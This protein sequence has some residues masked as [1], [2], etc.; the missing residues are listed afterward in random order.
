M[1]KYLNGIALAVA[2]LCVVPVAAWS[3]SAQA[4]QGGAQQ[5]G[6]SYTMPEYNQFTACQAE[7][8]P[9]SKVK[10]LDGFVSQFPNSTLMQYVDV[11]YYQT[12]Y[13]LKDLK[14][15]IDYA[16]KL[17]ALGD[18]ADLASRVSAMEFRVQ[19]FPY[20]YTTKDPDYQT[21]LTKQRDSALEAVKLLQ[22]YKTAPNS[23]LTDADYKKYLAVDYAAAG[24][25][26]LQLKDNTDAVTAF[27]SALDNNPNDALTEYHLGLAYLAL[28]PPQ[29]LDGF[30]ALARAVDLKVPDADKV[31]DYLRRAMLAYEQPGCVPQ[32]D[33]QLTDLLQMAA[34]SPTRPATYTIPSAD[35]LNKL[36][37]S[38]DTSNII[39][40]INSLS[41][42]GDN[43]KMTWLAFCG[44]EYPEVVGK[45]ID[46]QK[47]DGYVDFMVFTGATSQEMQSATMPNMDVKVWTAPPPPGAVPTP[48]ATGDAGTQG[49]GAG[50]APQITPQPDVLKLGKDDAIRFSG[51]VVSYDPSPFM[52]HWDSVKVDPSIIPQK[53]A[54]AKRPV[55]RK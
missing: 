4:A 31:K 3:V 9:A 53:A 21:Q 36:R 11:I 24:N 42:G 55:R 19:V 16:D 15:A 13:Q 48:P 37:Q 52:L 14:K 40:V 38:N 44:A 20:A 41:A 45:I 30:W 35:D 49:T 27:K 50:A 29:S 18:K 8:D 25:A 28:T 6:P 51:T 34:N 17:V 23:K 33:P 43:A 1:R 10:C 54:P 5:K 39:A 22:Q 47:S 26:D 32:V 46:V 12:Y 2:A 7:K